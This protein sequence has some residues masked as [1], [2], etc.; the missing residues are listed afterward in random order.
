M[1][2]TLVCI[3]G[4]R[5]ECLIAQKEK[6]KDEAADMEMESESEACLPEKEQHNIVSDN[7]MEI[8]K[9]D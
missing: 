8:E 3:P 6:E 5:A 4:T 7:D 1:H 9:E 2:V